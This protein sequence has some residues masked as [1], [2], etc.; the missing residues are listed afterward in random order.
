MDES[1]FQ[2]FSGQLSAFVQSREQA[3]GELVEFGNAAL[4]A[5]VIFEH[6]SNQRFG[7]QCSDR[8]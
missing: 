8:L 5:I 6:A 2:R 1:G 7:S 4:G 3:A